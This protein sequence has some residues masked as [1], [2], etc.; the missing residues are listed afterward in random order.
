M[1][2]NKVRFI[3]YGS[4][5]FNLQKKHITNL[6]L[7]SNYF[8]SSFAYG[9]EHLNKEFVREY[10]E[11]L[12]KEKGGGFWIWKH[13]IIK[14]EISNLKEGDILVYSDAGSSI[15]LNARKRFDEYIEML[16][17]SEYS[18]LRF[19]LNEIEKYWTTKEIFDYFKIKLDSEHANSEQF[20]AG[21][22]FIKNNKN[23]KEQLKIFDNLLSQDR[24]LITDAYDENQID[25]FI[26]NR[27]D[28]SIFSLIS[29]IYGCVSVGNEVWFKD[30]PEVQYNYPF[31]AVQQ[32]KY[33]IWQKIKFYL[34]Q[35]KH[36]NSSIF[37]GKKLYI[38][39]KPSLVSRVLFK[40]KK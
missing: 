6:A 26:E 31:L 39:Q 13:Q 33:T 5:N 28:Q 14:Q 11:I 35:K 30:S 3:T 24:Y 32:S 12:N 37:F 29:K 15:N 19:R 16:N 27:H 38:Y 23:L 9:P 22:L 7:K 20:L 36:L 21:H 4:N 1:K 40:L 8:D 34:N 18:M 25:D 17:S 10:K 2:N